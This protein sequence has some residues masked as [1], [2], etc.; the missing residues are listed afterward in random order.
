MGI[1][2]SYIVS[3]LFMWF[4][5]VFI[6]A[7]LIFT[8]PRLAPGDPIAGMVARMT[9]QSGYVENSK[10]LIEAW[11]EKFGLD[12]PWYVQ[13]GRYLWNCLTFDFGYSLTNFPSRVA[14]MMGR[15][16]PWTIGLLTVAVIITFALGNLIG[17]LMG[18]RK[19]PDIVRNLL[20]IALT[21]SSIPPFIFGLLLLF[22]FAYTLDIL[23]NQGGYDAR[24][25]TP[26]LTLGFIGSVAQHAVLPALAIVLTSMGGWALG[27][28]GMMITTDGEDYMI[29]AQ[30]KGLKAS[31]LFLRY[32]VRNALLPQLTA[33]ALSLGLLVGGSTLVETY[34]VYP[35]IGYLLYFAITN[36]D[37]TL[38][39]GIVY[40]LILTTATAVLIIDLLYPLID[41][42][43]ARR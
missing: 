5:T 7:T 31:R 27:M 1:S 33:L 3:R 24:N 28:R 34:F 36:G 23:P 16:L 26:G 2:R 32:A 18:W 21:F 37:Y 4:V 43:I 29:L 41:P 22:I 9:F 11:R 15:A 35:G 40:V 14:D 17:A 13:Y 30:A 6:G 20:P 42:R 12:G 38:M 19:T 25:F 39:Q 10:A 8:I